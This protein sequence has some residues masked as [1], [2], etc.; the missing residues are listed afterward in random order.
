MSHQ[1]KLRLLT[2][3]GLAHHCAKEQERYF[4]RQSYDPQYCLE[5]FRRA[6]VHQNEHAWDIIH[7][8]F[9]PR[10]VGWVNRHPAFAD[11]GEEI[12]Y[13]VNRAFEKMWFAMTPARFSDFA[14]LPP[15][16]VYLQMCVSS[17]IIDHTR[18]A[19]HPSVSLTGK[20]APGNNE[21]QNLNVENTAL[22][23]VH[24]HELSKALKAR[25]RG[26]Q[27]WHMA[28]GTFF[29]GLKPREI[30]THFPEM[31]CSVQEVYRVKENVLSRLRRDAEFLKLLDPDA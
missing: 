1:T 24:Q 18:R 9:S 11:S 14:D 13:F 22:D 21:H 16:L 20:R 15:L 23:H 31:F 12:Q 7:S 19:E 5:L 25:M 6:I 30:H 10:V 3:T 28:Y 2:L 27:E 17:V 8:Q 29:L 26:E 4:Q